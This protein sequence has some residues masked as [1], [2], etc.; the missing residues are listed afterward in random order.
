MI[1]I[2]LADRT[3]PSQQI[4]AE[5]L[6]AVASGELG[7]D[8]RLPTVRQL[9]GDLGVAP[10]TVQK[11]YAE[12]ESDGVVVSH[13]RRGTFVRPLP[14]ASPAEG[15]RLGAAARDFVAMADQLGAHGAEMLAAISA[16]I[17]SRP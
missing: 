15:A 10:G 9:A 13:G 6:R 11:A 3:P 4:R 2:D 8:D 17:A 5:V 12:L 7:A 1:S 16:A 14:S